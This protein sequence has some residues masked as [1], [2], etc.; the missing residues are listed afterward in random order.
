M[1]VIEEMRISDLPCAIT[2]W[3]SIPE[4][5]FSATFDSIERLTKFLSHN[6]GLSTI[7]RTENS[8]IGAVLC[9]HDGRRGFIYHT[10]VESAYRKQGIAKQ[11]VERCFEMLRKEDIDTCFL[12]TGNSNTGAQEFWKYMGFDY[13]S[14][15]MYH[16]RA[17]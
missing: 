10:G 2:L 14:H 5:S 17:I 9:G 15:I 12:F 6:T 4:L 16:S 11:M 1:I 3:S 8:I 13:A 7:A